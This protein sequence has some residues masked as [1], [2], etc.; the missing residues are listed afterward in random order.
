MKIID[1]LMGCF[2][3]R[4]YEAAMRLYNS[5]RYREAIEL[6]E[7]VLRRKSSQTSLHR[8]LANF[9]RCYAHRNL[10][11]VLFV[12]GNYP[13]AQK[14]FEQALCCCTNPREIYQL[15]G[16][17]QNNIGDYENA[18]R[19]FGELLTHNPDS[20]P[21]KLRLGIALHNLKMW[22]K[23][24]A[25]YST[26]LAQKPRYADVHFRLGLALL[27]QGKPA[28]AAEAFAS[29]IAINP[30]YVEAHVKLGL[31]QAYLGQFDAAQ[32]SFTAIL[33]RHPDFADI[34]HALGIV[35]AGL[36][37]MQDAC[38]AF[39]QALKVNPYYKDALIKLSMLHCHLGD[40][41][42]SA[43]C[44]QEAGRIDPDDSSLQ[45]T[46]VAV[47]DIMAGSGAEASIREEL[48]RLFGGGRPVEQAIA[49]FN[50]HLKIKPDLSTVLSIV[51]EFS[52]EETGLLEMLLPVVK[53]VVREHPG[54]PDTHN[55]LGG[56]YLKLNRLESAGE[57]FREALRLN[58]D[59]LRARVNL[60]NVLKTM[61]NNAEAAAEGE[62][63]LESNAEYPD[64]CFGM[65]E[66]LQALGR[67]ADALEYLARAIGLR[68]CYIQA[69]FLRARLLV[70]C[71]R[72]AEAVQA[73]EACLALD[74]GTE[75]EKT[76]REALQ[77]LRQQH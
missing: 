17:C 29:A 42:A 64:V 28:S 52:E 57:C 54:Y 51:K 32:A 24:V 59:Y 20:V 36:N 7:S 58:P 48:L 53:D 67:S 43:A 9:Y 6:F 4:D 61:G 31:T 2:R 8:N 41:R 26:I 50:R 38:A 46:L 45:E 16:I 44:L 18:A 55:T 40:H 69:H 15:M 12:M 49:E 60:F 70:H 33:D 75:I 1:T 14:E 77:A 35:Y 62:R 3:D 19:T 10:G 21:I 23:S 71:E 11:I 30:G 56:M 65:G 63:I 47:A 25:L 66:M 13:E 73:Y 5:H 74:P 27:G 76:V 68:P 22:D 37:R 39:E 34:Y 72:H